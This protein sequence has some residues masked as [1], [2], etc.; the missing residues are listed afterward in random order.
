MNKLCFGVNIDI[1]RKL[2]R[3]EPADLC[4]VDPPFNSKRNYKQIYNIRLVTYKIKM[5]Y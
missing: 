4:Y 5:W 2:V 3:D 1:L